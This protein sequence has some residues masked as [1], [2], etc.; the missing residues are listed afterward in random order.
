MSTKYEVIAKKGEGYNR[1]YIEEKLYL[2][3][4]NDEGDIVRF[5]VVIESFQFGIIALLDTLVCG[6]II[7]DA[8]YKIVDN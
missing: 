7:Y 3:V 2:S 8:S 6:S 5:L 1:K 4:I